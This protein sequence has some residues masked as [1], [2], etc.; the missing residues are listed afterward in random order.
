[1]ITLLL[2]LALSGDSLKAAFAAPPD[3]ARPEV[4]WY[5]MEGNMTREGMTADLEAMKKAGLGGGI[6]LEVDLGIPRGPV[7]YMSP[8]WR[9]HI[10]H[11]VHEADR[12]GLEIQ[13]GTGPGWCGTGGPWVKPEQ[14]MQHLVASEV[15]VQGPKKF[16]GALP[17]PKPR[18]PF[19][20]MGTLTPDLKAE[21]EGFYQDEAVLAFEA[22]IYPSLTDLDEKALIYRAPFSS[23]PGVK[24]YLTFDKQRKEGF[25]I[26]DQK[27]IDLTSKFK[28]GRLQWDVPFGKWTILRFGRTLTGQ[29]S[30]P[31]PAAGLGFETDKFTKSA[32]EAHLDTYVDSIVKEVGMARH[33]GKGLTALHFDSWEMGA[34]N[35]SK[36]FRREFTK[37]RGYDPLTYLPVLAG[38]IV[39]QIDHSER[40][41]WD[42]RQ[43]AQEL[44]VE[45]HMGPIKARARKYGLALELEP[46]D[47]NPAADLVLGATADIPMCEFWSKG[48]GFNSEYSCFEAVSLGHIGGHPVVGAEAFTADYDEA[49]LQHPGSMKAQ[50]DW[51]LAAGINKLY[52]HRYQHQPEEN[53]FPGMTM[54]GYGVH[55]E[56]T[57]TWWDLV[58]PFHTYLA[59]CQHLLRQGQA[60]ADI[61]YL[62]PEGAPCVF[63]AP[64]SA[65]VG[66]LPDRRGYNFDACSADQLLTAKVKDG[67]IVFPSGMA[68]RVLVLPQIDTM[69]VRLARK[70]QQ[71]AMAGA[72][73]I[74]RPAVQSPSLS[75][76]P[77]GD[78]VVRE[79]GARLWPKHAIYYRSPENDSLSLEGAQWIW[80]DEGDA[81]VASPTGSRT[82]R[83][84]VRLEYLGSLKLARAAF[85][86]DNLLTLRVNGNEVLSGADFHK[87]GQV[88]LL[89]YLKVGDNDFE[90]T[91]VNSGDKPNP[92][93]LIGKIALTTEDS[94]TT[95]IVTDQKWQAEGH[96]VEELGDWNIGPWNL[97][98]TISMPELYPPYEVTAGVLRKRLKVQP[99]VESGAAVR[100]CHRRIGNRDVY[101]I[102]NRTDSLFAGEVTFRATGK[103]EWW[104]PLTGTVHPLHLSAVFSNGQTRIP[105]RLEANQSGFVVFGGASSAGTGEN[106]PALQEVAKLEGPWQVSFEPRFGGPASVV[107][108]SLVDW[109]SRSEPG[110][111]FY[112]GKAIYRNKFDFAGSAS[113]ID[114]GVVKNIAGVRLNGMDLGV[115][116]CAPFRLTIPA[117]VLKAIGNELE[118]TVANLWPNRLI[119]DAGLP[120]DKRI[121]KTTWSPFRSDSPLLPSGLH[122]PVRLMR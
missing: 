116:W 29:T 27:I 38:K 45:N 89:P 91:V 90:A 25:A 104:D 26:F 30:R 46:Y 42:L 18:T 82:F 115:G 22:S 77:A 60:V 23:Q 48:Y 56:R 97:T 109:T 72:T 86:A 110:I 39:N 73:M 55:W 108:D 37:R 58:G 7:K 53:R 36:D 20:G 87:V 119:G 14:S 57:Q 8:E 54:G 3:T 64:A 100:F 118:I 121:T 49:W 88:D 70:L 40:F 94:Y 106:F 113:A 114:L 41:L 12:L 43:T 50:A 75:D 2:T 47:M 96:R 101:F 92:A 74:G 76:Y 80:T 21:W 62:T 31:A 81:K 95:T 51:A 6:F 111:R 1:M 103:A 11:A 99:D 35:W 102:A 107:F 68:Y 98:P 93:G 32:I 59:R 65:T 61:L 28:N 79:V 71:L 15:T 44:V 83:R 52:F 78:Q 9:Q 66:T 84:T 69:T 63:Q 117:G 19:F 105:F 33:P 17:Q 112:S 34:Q 24:P 85:T 10:A 5:F 13:L 67:Q 120:E 122:G 16:E 4:Y